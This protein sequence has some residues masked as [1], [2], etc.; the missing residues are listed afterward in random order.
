MIFRMY[1]LLL[2]FVFLA[3]PCWSSESQLKLIAPAEIRDRNDSVLN[4]LWKLTVK[5]SKLGLKVDEISKISIM[6]KK[7]K[8][9]ITVQNGNPKNPNNLYV[10]E[11]TEISKNKE[12]HTS[13]DEDKVRDNLTSILIEKKTKELIASYE[14]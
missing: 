9:F 6:N 1:M 14:N 13:T 7:N 11:H 10:M 4:E 5:N 3:N 2:F 8:S 12:Q